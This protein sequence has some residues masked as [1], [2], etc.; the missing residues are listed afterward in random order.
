MSVAFR[1][2]RG[3]WLRLFLG[4]NSVASI[5]DVVFAPRISVRI[6]GL[7]AVV[8]GLVGLVWGDFAVVWQPVP[9]GVPGQTAWGYA[10]AVPFL[11]AGLAI[12]WQ[13]AA[14]L[15]VLAL[16]LLYSLAVIFL[17][18]PRVIAHP[19]V[20]VTW[21]G[22]AE[23]LALAAGGL[24]AY[25][26]CA[27]FEPAT[28]E[29]LSKIGRRI[30]GACLIVFGL[31]HL[32]YLAYTA[33]MVPKWLPPGQTFWAYATAAGHFAAG[34]AILSG[35]AARLA[36]MLLTA[37]FVVFGILVHAPTIFIDPHTHFNWAE[38]AINFALI[39]SAWVIAASIGSSEPTAVKCKALIAASISCRSSMIP[40][41]GSGE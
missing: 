37:M 35:I 22:V 20:F 15:G 17:D 6:Y 31:A 36:A 28:A 32:F 7:S 2:L 26:Y 4:E 18:V 8:L 5:L 29:R 12:Q 3:T 38:N 13:R 21:Y 27:R 39:G 9:D 24:V 10:A 34:I 16:T 23:T 41:S 14:Y 1:W 30:F 19:S 33:K 25:A 11:L 40:K